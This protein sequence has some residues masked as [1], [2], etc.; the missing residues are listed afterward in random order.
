MEIN[1]LRP[2]FLEVLRHKLIAF[3]GG[4]ALVPMD[5]PYAEYDNYA[6]AKKEE[7]NGKD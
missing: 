5:Y 1:Y 4:R 2:R 6:F 3:L 7:T